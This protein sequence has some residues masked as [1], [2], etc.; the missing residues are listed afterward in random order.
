MDLSFHSFKKII[1]INELIKGRLNMSAMQIQSLFRSKQNLNNKIQNEL[2][3]EQKIIQSSLNK[4]KSLKSDLRKTQETIQKAFYPSN[5]NISL[6]YK[7]VG[8]NQYV[9][10]RFYWHGQQREVQVG[11]L[12]IILKLIHEMFDED[13]FEG[14]SFP[15]SFELTWQDFLKNENL[16]LATK[17]IA[18]LKFQE[19]V[20]RK[21]FNEGNKANENT[22]M[23]DVGRMKHV[24]QKDVE[25]ININNP[26]DEKY[27]WYEK[28]REDNL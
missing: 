4:I 24:I 28:W 20:L 19:Y 11:S 26:I 3:K 6:L 25:N 21:I 5:K 13:Y 23:A 16:I 8:K 12:E 9:K 15:D 17:E 22:D 1:T 27:E 2:D 10:G 18:A 14:I 7:R